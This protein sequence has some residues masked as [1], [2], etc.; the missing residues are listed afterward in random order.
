[1]ADGNSRD[2]DRT[3]SL[4]LT[5][6]SRLEHLASGTNL[7]A[8]GGLTSTEPLLANWT[9]TF[10]S[11]AAQFVAQFFPIFLLGP[12]SASSWNRAGRWKQLPPV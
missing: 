8:V 9:E 1:M 7:R 6:L 11:N 4:D 10:M 12:C 3:W 5:C 2:P